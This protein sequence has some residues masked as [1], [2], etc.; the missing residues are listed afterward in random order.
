MSK[1]M[2]Q[3]VTARRKEPIAAPW[4]F[5]P[6]LLPFWLPVIGPLMAGLVGGKKA[7]GVGAAIAAVFLPA[8]FVGILL[9]VLFTAIG[10]PFVGALTGGIA[11]LT[12]A[13]TMIG[14]LLIGTVIGGVLA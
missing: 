2:A 10:L 7:G 14:P 4:V 1:A 13:A 11:F 6:S 5:L 3:R 8:V 12:V 9:F